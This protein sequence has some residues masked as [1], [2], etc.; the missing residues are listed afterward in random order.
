MW[1]NVVSFLSPRWCDT[2]WNIPVGMRVSTV[3]MHSKF[4][5]LSISGAPVILVIVVA[6]C[7]KLLTLYVYVSEQAKC[8]LTGVQRNTMARLILGFNTHVGD[9]SLW[10]CQSVCVRVS[11]SPSKLAGSLGRFVSIW[12]RISV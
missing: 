1:M 4:A 3:C 5:A 12:L 11:L 6:P 7:D 8:S 2:N 9:C 10:K